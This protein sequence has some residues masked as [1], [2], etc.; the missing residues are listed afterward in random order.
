M[1]L[2]NKKEIFTNYT[3]A[4]WHITEPEEYFIDNLEL[5]ALEK[6]ELH[7][8]RGSKRKEW[9]SARMLLHILS[10]NGSRLPMYKDSFGKPHLTDD[11]RKLSISHSHDFSAI[12]FSDKHIGIDIQ[13][14]LPKIKRI[15]EKFLHPEELASIPEENSLSFLHYYWGAKESMYKAYGKKELRF[16]EQ[17]LID[18]FEIQNNKIEC[19]GRI[20]LP[21][22]EIRFS[23]KGEKIDEYYIVYAI[24]K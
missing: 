9:L 14:E 11:P 13:K 10:E 2:F 20:I 4:I 18:L 7:L 5:S 24:E 8:I 6:K 1:P 16:A 23:V 21:D 15:K 22:Y 3:A 12:A 19:G 17:I